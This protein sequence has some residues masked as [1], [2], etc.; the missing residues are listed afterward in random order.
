MKPL[1][2]AVKECLLKLKIFEIK[3][4]GG[5]MNQRAELLNLINIV[6]VVHENELFSFLPLEKMF[7][8]LISEVFLLQ[9]ENSKIVEN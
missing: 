6:S 1:Y 9:R 8:P 5:P 7:F 3:I 2:I 4:L